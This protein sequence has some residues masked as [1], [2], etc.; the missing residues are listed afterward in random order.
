MCGWSLNCAIF[1]ENTQL[2]KPDQSDLETRPDPDPGQDPGS[3]PDPASYLYL[4]FSK[5]L[6]SP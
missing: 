6:E 5:T 1:T 2:S 4:G 3:S